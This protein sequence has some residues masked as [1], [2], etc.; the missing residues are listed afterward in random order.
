MDLSVFAGWTLPSKEGVKVLHE[1]NCK[2]I[3]LGLNNEVRFVKD[4]IDPVTG[5]QKYK[6]LPED[7]FQ[8]RWKRGG[9]RAYQ[10]LVDSIHMLYEEGFDV[11]LCSWL[12][13]HEDY[14]KTKHDFLQRL[15]EDT[16]ERVYASIEDV[17]GYYFKHGGAKRVDKKTFVDDVYVP[18]MSHLTDKVL[19]GTTSFAYVPED[20]AYLSKQ[21][22]M[23]YHISQ[24]Y[25][26]YLP[27]KK[28]THESIFRPGNAT[29]LAEQKWS[30]FRTDFN[31]YAPALAVYGLYHPNEWVVKSAKAD[32]VDPNWALKNKQ[33][34]CLNK[35]I[36]VR[37]D[38]GY[39]ETIAW[40]LVWLTSHHKSNP[41]KNRAAEERRRIL[42][43]RFG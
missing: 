19:L 23:T 43:E 2:H 30:K 25:E 39:D 7:R 1:V 11:S 14:V 9:E 21:E 3:V 38:M 18:T 6:T 4:G 20:V 28:M 33:V 27:K 13:P 8:L 24:P 42:N 31:I 37:E 40:S 35:S 22:C 10:A 17:E 15:I 26:T 16:D 32:G 41:A 36:Q 5:K 29:R 34:Y 12:R